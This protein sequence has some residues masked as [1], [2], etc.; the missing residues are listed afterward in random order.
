MTDAAA[1][2]AVD[3]SPLANRIVDTLIHRIGKDERAARK[4]DWL[5]ATILT[6]RDEIID[7]WMES[8][9][10]AHASGA[11][12]VYYLSLE[13]LIGRLLR[14][15]LSNLGRN[16]EVK[17]ALASLGVDL[18]EI[19]EIEPDAAL[20]NGG[21][22]RLAACFMES[23]ATLE[24]SAYGYGIRYVNG[25]FRQRIDDG[26]QV[27]LPETWLTHG[28]P[29][30]FER[31]E[32]AYFIGFGGEV[33]SNA[34]GRVDW[35]PAE[36]VEA[37]AFDTPVVGWRGKRVNTLRLWSARAFDPIRLDAFNAGDHAG[38][39]AGQVRAE[40]LVRV[41]YPSDASAAGQELRLRQEY[42]FSSAS[43]Q[44][45]V[46]R[47]MQYFGDI[48]LLP[49]KAAIQLN[50]T[51]PAISVA[52]L[53]RLLLD[54]HELDFD[55]A[56]DIARRTFGYTNHTLLPEALESWPLPLFERLLP[57]HMQ[58]VYAINAQVLREA[59]RSGA[60]DGGAI[61]AISLID[62]NGERRI[63]MANLAFVGSH[64]VN[65]VA[66]LHTELMKQTVF[67]DL[68]RLYP[69]RINNKTNGIT[70]RRW[71][72][73]CN[74]R[75]TSLIR[76]AIGPA[77]CDDAEQLKLLES[78]AN[79]ASFR[80]RFGEVKR[81]NKVDL[82]NYL[83]EDQGL[84]V[85]PDA[86]FDV[87]VKRIHEYKRQL[88]NIIETVALYDQIRSHPERD[89]VPRVKL[90]GG[91]AAS[92]YHNA[93]LIIKLAN[94]VAKRINS[95]P[96]VGGLLKV[97]F[98]PNYNVSL[99]ERII[100]AADLSEQIST[101]GMEA[102]GT[103]NMKFAL[104]GAITIGTLDGANIE[105]K[106]RV[107]DDN[108]VIFGLTADEVAETRRAGYSPRSIIENSREL[109]QA[110]NAIASGVFSPDDPGRYRD[111]MSGLYDHD[112]FMVAADFDAYAATQRTVDA[113]WRDRG[114]W[115][116]SA[117]RNVAN[118]GWFSSDRTIGEYA[119]DIWNVM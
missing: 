98:I 21:L 72:M 50:D 118:V 43:I 100:P 29:W 71:L 87:Q 54:H 30:E 111:L 57:R 65:G 37:V 49:E 95:D 33:T 36:A 62:E 52:E 40:A 82:S 22:G 9:R 2:P 92:S 67:A 64:S 47:H 74:P 115:Q 56:W 107:G 105:I 38:A 86:L 114:G 55:E 15:A 78:F 18:D 8:T 61:A 83:R 42:F 94:D 69:D 16:A 93:K 80:E 90:F 7:K 13:F 108:I 48:R 91:K 34:A 51:H 73:E 89:W 39:L 27:E 23:M 28:N 102:S 110:I 5:D 99:A 79:D 119:R 46:R 58:I 3:R 24:L 45:V 112:W 116:A 1:S 85:D 101:A 4:H 14:D 81:S 97:G 63:R 31:R 11:K 26:W 41:L 17:A 96:A 12:R 75:L 70:P 117:I 76:D 35:N 103:G 6:L 32:S 25:M 106:D 113:R 66:A 77:F 68:H 104:N 59:A 19:E 88:L 44:D 10:A 60:A 109:S 84:R 20:G 53:M